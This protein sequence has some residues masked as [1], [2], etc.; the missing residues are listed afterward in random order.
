[1]QSSFYP[2]DHDEPIITHPF[3]NTANTATPLTSRDLNKGDENIFGAEKAE[4]FSKSVSSKTRFL[5][6]TP[7]SKTVPKSVQDTIALVVAESSNEFEVVQ[8]P[9]QTRVS[10]H[11]TV[12]T[13]DNSLN[14]VMNEELL[15]TVIEQ[16][17]E[18]PEQKAVS[19]VNVIS[20]ENEIPEEMT[21]ESENVC[22]SEQIATDKGRIELEVEVEANV[23]EKLETVQGFENQET[24]QI[25][26]E[27][28]Q[29][30]P[31]A[32]ND[33]ELIEKIE[34]TQMEV[35]FENKAL[36]NDLT[37]DNKSNTNEVHFESETFIEV[38]PEEQPVHKTED[39]LAIAE[40]EAQL[41]SAVF[42]VQEPQAESDISPVQE[43][44]E[45]TFPKIETQEQTCLDL[46]SSPPE[47]SVESIQSTNS[48]EEAPKEDIILTTE[49][50]AQASETLEETDK[51]ADELNQEDNKTLEVLSLIPNPPPENSLLQAVE[52]KEAI[53]K[54]V[55]DQNDF[56]TQLETTDDPLALLPAF[57]M[58]YLKSIP[59]NEDLLTNTETINFNT[60]IDS[61]ESPDRML[62]NPSQEASNSMLA[63]NTTTSDFN[64]SDCRN[65][66]STFLER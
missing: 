5:K 18:I 21:I 19:E 7:I 6:K 25:I 53:T 64:W 26:E 57:S 35:E 36:E 61:D 59:D 46:E 12:S 32:N 1:M 65:N 58:D 10:P 14:Q 54:L 33:V 30:E 50:I 39:N 17:S 62:D 41:E 60:K 23:D 40:T 48:S 49:E 38:Q 4:K 66:A 20:T 24:D 63:G 13:I 9:D 31:V 42:V 55:E 44:Q 45:S 29:V 8:E 52:D 2:A 22:L 16:E 28:S 27:P 37:T 43:A 3:E 15:P 47:P 34:N 11:E 56:E 51:P